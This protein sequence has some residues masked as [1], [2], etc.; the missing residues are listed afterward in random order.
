MVP[1]NLL[2]VGID[3]ESRGDAGAR[4]RQLL[5]SGDNIVKN[6]DT[7]DRHDRARARYLQA[8]EVAETAGLD[9]E[10]LGFIDARLA[11]L[12]AGDASS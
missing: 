5:L 1:A 7:A 6:R 4:V 3:G 11:G 2:G 10:I 8:R 9:P 12:T